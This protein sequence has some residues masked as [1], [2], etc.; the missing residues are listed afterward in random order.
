MIVVITHFYKDSILPCSIHCFKKMN[1][2]YIFWA[3]IESAI[4]QGPSHPKLLLS[5]ARWYIGHHSPPASSSVTHHRYACYYLTSEKGKKEKSRNYFYPQKIYPRFD[6]KYSFQH[7]TCITNIIFPVNYDCLSTFYQILFC[8]TYLHVF[9]QNYD[10]IQNYINFFYS[11]IVRDTGLSHC[12]SPWLLMFSVNIMDYSLCFT[13]R[14]LDVYLQIDAIWETF[15]YWALFIFLI[16]LITVSHH[17]T[18]WW[19]LWDTRTD[20]A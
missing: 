12:D 11:F 4:L 10:I 2:W 15:P 9:Y 6:E 13:T 3:S 5:Q 18:L 19:E 16:F 17:H 14:P 20:G 7:Q 1:D 8:S